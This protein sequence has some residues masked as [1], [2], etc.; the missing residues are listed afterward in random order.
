MKIVTFKASRLEKKLYIPFEKYSFYSFAM[1]MLILW[2]K[3]KLSYPNKVDT[4]NT[5]YP[6]KDIFAPW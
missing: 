1:E 5:L 2:K 6:N 3:L 4:T